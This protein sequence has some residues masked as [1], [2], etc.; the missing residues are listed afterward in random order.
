M[1]LR[2]LMFRAAAGGLLLAAGIVSFIAAGKAC[3]E[4]ATS[5]PA[6]VPAWGGQ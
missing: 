5:P 1:T 2:V 3:A 4:P 6:A